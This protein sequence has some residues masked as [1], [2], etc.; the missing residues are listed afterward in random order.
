MSL[1]NAAVIK[2][3]LDKAG[4]FQGTATEAA[5]EC[6]LSLSQFNNALHSIRNNADLLG[7]TIPHVPCG[8][9]VKNWRVV[10]VTD[11]SSGTEIM[12]ADEHMLNHI[13]TRFRTME[14]PVQQMVKHLDKRTVEGKRALALASTISHGILM[15]D[16]LDGKA[17]LTKK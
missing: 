14:K 15:L 10:T 11:D 3:W 4:T 2:F 7:Y 1:T 6:G 5:D 12:E 9:G 8:S 16:V 13:E 17:A